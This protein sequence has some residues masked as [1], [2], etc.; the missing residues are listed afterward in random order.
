MSKQY[1]EIQER[2][3]EWRA[4]P[5]ALMEKENLRAVVAPLLTGAEKVLELACGS[6]FYTYDLVDWGAASVTAIDISEQMIQAA[7]RHPGHEVHGDKVKLLVADACEPRSLAEEPFDLAVAGWLLTYAPDKEAL[8]K[9]FQTVAMNLKPGGR[10]ITTVIKPSSDPEILLRTGCVQFWSPSNF[11]IEPVAPVAD[12]M[13]IS[14]IASGTTSWTSY[15]LRQEV[16]ATA[17]KAA[18]FSTEIEYR[19]PFVSDEM[20]AAFPSGEM[21]RLKSGLSSLHFSLLIASK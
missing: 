11:R 21:S 4:C 16:Y 12:G 8:T 14:C 18:G 17:A 1:N 2:Y 10:F 19:E 5:E 15:Y 13:K 9:M 20:A 6:G 7:R 3:D